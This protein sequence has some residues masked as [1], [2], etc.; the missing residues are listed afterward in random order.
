MAVDSALH[1]FAIPKDGEEAES[2][3][4]VVSDLD[5]PFLPIPE[6]LLVPLSEARLN[7]EKFLTGLPNMFQNNQNN[8]SCMGSAL[9]SGHK[10]I[11]PLG[12]KLVVLSA[13]LP[14]IGAGKLEMRED[15]K[16]LGTSKEGSLLQTAN[17]FYKSFAVECSKNQVSVDMFLFSS[18]YQDGLFPQ[19]SVTRIFS[20]CNPIVASLSNLPRY[21]GGQTYFYPGY[22]LFPLL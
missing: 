9:R 13:S 22:G 12:G 19:C 4:L 2:R 5:E 16:L 20:N 7:V 14:N 18:T 6:G 1:F 11:S 21:T 17:S 15:K 10:L 3:S 8:G